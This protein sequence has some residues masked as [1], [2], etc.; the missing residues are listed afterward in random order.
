MFGKMLSTE[1]ANNQ[2]TKRYSNLQLEVRLFNHFNDAFDTLS[3][4]GYSIHSSVIH[5]YPSF[6][7]FDVPLDF[8]DDNKSSIVIKELSDLM[9]IVY[10]P[11]QRIAKFTFM[12]NKV[13]RD[14]K[15]DLF[16]FKADIIQYYLLKRKPM[17][18]DS[19]LQILNRNKNLL[20]KCTFESITSYGLFYKDGSG[21]YEMSYYNTRFLCDCEVIY[22]VKDRFAVRRIH[23]VSDFDILCF[24][25][26]TATKTIEK[27]GNYLINL[28]IG[29][30]MT[31]SFHRTFTHY[32]QDIPSDFMDLNID[33]DM[34][35]ENLSDDRN[36]GFSGKVV[37][38]NSDMKPDNQELMKH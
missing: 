5:S 11:K 1:F 18:I 7:R 34:D 13:S 30:N 25:D 37:Y 4:K 3:K 21:L 9:I 6:T 16:S 35:D 10:S 20:R 31:K 33:Y 19:V 22:P 28:N 17:I 36:M 2:K 27:F 14:K 12:Q 26:L 8:L 24:N 29:D 32:V 15:I 38:I 23:L